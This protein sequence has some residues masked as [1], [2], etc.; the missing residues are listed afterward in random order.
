MPQLRRRGRARG[1]A[2]GAASW[3]RQ[4]DR[5]AR[6]TRCACMHTLSC[7]CD[8]GPRRVAQHGARLTGDRANRRQGCARAP[9]ASRYSACS[10]RPAPSRC[11][12]SSVSCS[13]AAATSASSSP[14][15]PP[16]PGPPAAP[17]AGRA[18]M[19]RRRVGPPR[20]GQPRAAG[21]ASPAGAGSGGALRCRPWS[22]A[23]WGCALCPTST[24][25]KL[26]V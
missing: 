19:R 23:L 17:E 11:S 2:R 20:K 14:P 22:G 8:T 21:C 16:P 4:N 15:P 1:P 24:P 13:A 3:L 26:H 6:A 7:S 10:A 25:T 18:W 12:A 9:S 5:G